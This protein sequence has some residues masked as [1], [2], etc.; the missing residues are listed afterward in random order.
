MSAE[1]PLRYSYDDKGNLLEFQQPDRTIDD[2]L[3]MRTGSRQSSTDAFGQTT[4]FEYDPVIG[5]VTKVTDPTKSV[6]TTTYTT[7][8]FRDIDTV[9]KGNDPTVSSDDVVTEF[10]VR[11]A[12]VPHRTD[13][14]L[15]IR[16]DST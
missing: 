7:G 1:T 3:G 13:R 5:K 14:G 10:H 12:G 16:I 6:T 8:L 11:A 2:R 15:W 9:T 4:A